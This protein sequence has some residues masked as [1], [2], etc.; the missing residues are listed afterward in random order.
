LQYDATAFQR[1]GR[2]NRVKA[3]S[4]TGFCNSACAQLLPPSADTITRLMQ[5]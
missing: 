2:R 5:P 4:S 1:H 3:L